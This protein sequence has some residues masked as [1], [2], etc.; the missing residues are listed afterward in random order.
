MRKSVREAKALLDELGKDYGQRPFLELIHTTVS[1]QRIPRADNNVGIT[2]G[3]ARCEN[4]RNRRQAGLCLLEGYA[5]RAQSVELSAIKIR[6]PPP[7][8]GFFVS[9]RRG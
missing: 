1:K 4:S 7:G 3:S 6:L 9:K 8:N 5:S 2:G